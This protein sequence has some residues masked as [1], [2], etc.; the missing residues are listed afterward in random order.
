MER[1]R[2]QVQRYVARGRRRADVNN[3]DWTGHAVLSFLRDIGSTSGHGCWPADG[4][5]KRLEAGLSYRVLYVLLRRGLPPAVPQPRVRVAFGGATRGQ[6]HGDGADPESDGAGSSPGEPLL[7]KADGRSSARRDRHDLADRSDLAVRIQQLLNEDEEG[8][9]YLKVFS[10]DPGRDEDL[11][12]QKPS[13]AAPRGATALAD[14]VQPWATTAERDRPPGGLA[15][16]VGRPRDWTRRTWRRVAGGR[17]SGVSPTLPSVV[18]VLERGGWCR[19]R[20]RPGAIAR[21]SILNNR[22]SRMPIRARRATC[23]R[24]YV[25]VRRGRR[26]SAHSPR[27]QL[28]ERRVTS[29][30]S[31][32]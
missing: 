24:P 4:S 8:G 26:P 12:R 17:R 23:C 28:S 9:E 30:P 14:D 11:A 27:S 22:R 20:A 18:E 19:A 15:I 2:S 13:S 25:I 1:L 5:G 32:E 21:R 6:Q 3:L 29:R 10:P 31:G 7:T 16:S